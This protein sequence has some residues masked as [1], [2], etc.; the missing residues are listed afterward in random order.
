MGDTSGQELSPIQEHINNTL[1][2]GKEN[3]GQHRLLLDDYYS[4]GARLNLD[5]LANALVRLTTAVDNTLTML[6]A[7][8]TNRCEEAVIVA[9]CPSRLQ[10]SECLLPAVAL[11][12]I[13]FCRCETRNPDSA[14][15]GGCDAAASSL[16]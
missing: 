16:W 11:E 10:K 14:A 2:A 4:A 12:P 7:D 6:A 9:G 15:G 13:W 5:M 8:W 1:T 3:L